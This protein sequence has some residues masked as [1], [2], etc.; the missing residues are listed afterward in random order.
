MMLPAQIRCYC[1]AGSID[2]VGKPFWVSAA[3]SGM[4]RKLPCAGCCQLDTAEPP[5]SSMEGLGFVPGCPLEA[6]Y[7]ASCEPRLWPMACARAEEEEGAGWGC[8]PAPWPAWPWAALQ[9]VAHFV[10]PESR[11]D[12]K[13]LLGSLVLMFSGS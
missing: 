3:L 12:T 7:M 4:P 8:D 1:V 11:G 10:A 5:C 13:H 2:H 9:H 6:Q